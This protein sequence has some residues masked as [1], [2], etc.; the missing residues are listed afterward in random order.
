MQ[1]VDHLGAD[2]EVLAEDQALDP[3]A[4]SRLSGDEDVIREE[5]RR[6]LVA[7]DEVAGEDV[8]ALVEGVV[9]ARDEGVVSGLEGD[10][11]LDGSE[12]VGGGGEVLGESERL[13]VEERWVYM[14]VGKDCSGE[15][16]D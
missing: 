9:D 13:G 12:G 11:V 3:L 6:G 4:V 16:V 8:V 1:G 15:R 5:E 7:V 2:G 10:G 14:V